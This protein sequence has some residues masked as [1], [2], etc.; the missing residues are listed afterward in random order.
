MADKY[1]LDTSIWV[2]FYDERGTK[3]EQAKLLLRKI[4]QEDKI[5]IFSDFIV[6]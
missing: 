1:Y 2:D 6:K 5:I 4:I 3:G